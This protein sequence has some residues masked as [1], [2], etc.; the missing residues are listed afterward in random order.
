MVFPQ[1]RFAG[2]R[3]EILLWVPREAMSPAPLSQTIVK[4]SMLARVTRALCSS[5]MV[6][7]IR[8]K[9]VFVGT[10]SFLRH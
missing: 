6:L 1:G 9:A 4:F 8:E 3:A 7:F 10:R 5:Y 2:I